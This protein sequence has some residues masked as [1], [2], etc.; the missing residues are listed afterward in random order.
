ML[1]DLL[2]CLALGFIAKDDDV[3]DAC[4]ADGGEE[5]EDAGL[6]DA[7]HQRIECEGDDEGQGVIEE[8]S[9]PTG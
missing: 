2:Q 3:A 9:D 4:E 1:L 7:A 8:Y 6:G 5:P